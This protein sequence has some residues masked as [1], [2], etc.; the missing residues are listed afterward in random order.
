MTKLRTTSQTCPHCE[1]N[2]IAQEIP[3]ESRP[4]YLPYGAE[5]DGRFLFFSKVVGI[6]CMERD[7]TVKLQCPFCG[8]TDTV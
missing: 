7:R 3:K 1:A 2:L 8:A 4:Y 6:Y 5:D